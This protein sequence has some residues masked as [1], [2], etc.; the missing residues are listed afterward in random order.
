[1]NVTH[2]VLLD[3]DNSLGY[4]HLLLCCGKRQQVHIDELQP[5]HWW[6]CAICEKPLML[7]TELGFF[8]VGENV[9]I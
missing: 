7:R 4:G 1:M 8:A 6:E 9:T 3:G 2:K 5:G